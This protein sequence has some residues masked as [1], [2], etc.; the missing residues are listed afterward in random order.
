MRIV[1]NTLVISLRCYNTNVR[2]KVQGFRL[3]LEQ[4]IS[5]HL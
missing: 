5:K 2:S 4:K 3:D 1:E